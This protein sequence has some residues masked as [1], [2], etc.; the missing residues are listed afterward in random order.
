MK[1]LISV[2]SCVMF[3]PWEVACS[4]ALGRLSAGESAHGGVWWGC[5]YGYGEME[6]VMVNVVT[7]LESSSAEAPSLRVTCVICKQVVGE[8]RGKS[9]AAEGGGG[10]ELTT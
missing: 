8:K 5:G 9:L 2:Y 4:L 1:P 10:E 6:M 7:Y 3:P